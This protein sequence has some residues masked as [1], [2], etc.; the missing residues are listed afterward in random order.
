MSEITRRGL[1]CL[2]AA[3]IF[4]LLRVGTD[5]QSVADG[6]QVAA[7]LFAVAGLALIGWGLVRD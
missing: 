6:F 5:G 4:A 1:F 2:C 3:G 7:L